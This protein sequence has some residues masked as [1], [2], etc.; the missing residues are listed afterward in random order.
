MF[1]ESRTASNVSGARAAISTAAV[2][3]PLG[4]QWRAELLAT[5]RAKGCRRSRMAASRATSV[6]WSNRARV[7]GTL[8]S[9]FELRPTDEQYRSTRLSTVRTLASSAA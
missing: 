3:R 5:S 7:G 1:S 9:S 2:R 8:S 4:L 6:S